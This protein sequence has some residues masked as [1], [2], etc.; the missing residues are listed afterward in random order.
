MAR[1]TAPVETEPIFYRE[2]ALGIIGALADILVA[3]RSIE[4]MVGG[5]DEEEDD[6]G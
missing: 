4:S 1:D 5:F 6:E 2:E 3:V